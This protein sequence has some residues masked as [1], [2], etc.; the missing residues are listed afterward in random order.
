MATYKFE[1]YLDEVEDNLV[2]TYA[3]ACSQEP[4]DVL[5]NIVQNNIRT[6]FV[7]KLVG[8]ALNAELAKIT[9][10]QALMRLKSFTVG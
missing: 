10:A 8:E 5:D 6:S 3:K 7:N 2:K 9:T 1:V 4:Q